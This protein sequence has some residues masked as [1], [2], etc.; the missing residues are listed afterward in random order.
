MKTL[1]LLAVSTLAAT[2]MSGCADDADTPKPRMDSSATDA[3][4]APAEAGAGD[5]A[6][7]DGAA[8]DAAA[9]PDGATVDAAVDA[10]A[11]D[12]SADGSAGDAAPTADAS[13]FQPQL[14]LTLQPTV[15]NT[16]DGM[17]LDPKTG[18]VILSCPNFFGGT[19]PTS[20]SA[21]PVLMKITPANALEMYV[22][23]LP[24]PGNVAPIP[25]RAGPM[26][27]DFGP[28]GNL[29]VA[30]H[31]YRYDVN[32][33]SRILRVN[34]NAAGKPTTVDVVVVGLRLSNA[35][36][37]NKDYLYISDTW[38]F[39]DATMGKSA[40]YRFTRAEL[41]AATTAAPIQLMKYTA[42]TKDPHMFAEFTTVPGR[43]VNLAGADGITFDAAGSLYTGNFG[44]GVMTKFTFD[45]AGVA[46]RVPT[47]FLVNPM[48]TCVD[49]IFFEA[50]T[51]WIYIADS[52]KNAVRRVNTMTNAFETLWENDDSP[53]TGGLL[54]QPAEVLVRGNDLLVVNFDAGFPAAQPGKNRT[55]DAPHTISV[56]KLR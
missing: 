12:A 9:T 52:Q 8:A 30:D 43:G 47:P 28:D 13:A 1:A 51:N 36:M 41:A 49:G 22:D 5:A 19:P 35:L 14:L 33:K 21:P 39:D 42:T 46:T 23:V 29:Y 37:W 7:G 54:D 10:G 40:I 11:V 2:G 44:D 56:I 6:A 20:F 3:T 45:A 55:H 53:G 26:G 31:Q 38:A 16:P 15:C 18:D 34:V 4:A 32:N 50:S 17:R 24:P 27:L 48:L 25:D